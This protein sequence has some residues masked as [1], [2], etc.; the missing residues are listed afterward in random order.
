MKCNAGRRTLNA[1]CLMKTNVSRTTLTAAY[2]VAICADFIQICL[3]PFYLEGFASPVDDF[4]DVVVCLILTRLIGFHFAFLPSFLIKLV[5]LVEG[6]PTWTLAVL[7]ASRH[8][9]TAP[10]IDV[11][12]EVTKTD[13]GESTV[14]PRILP[15]KEK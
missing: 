9:R 6:V 1:E 2:A 4:S 15:E 12:S 10:V 13:V 5:P 7:I 3:V 14:P 11:P 8:L